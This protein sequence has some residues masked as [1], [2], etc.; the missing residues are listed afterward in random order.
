MFMIKYVNETLISI[1]FKVEHF[2]S[3]GKYLHLGHK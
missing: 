3:N 2:D 1:M